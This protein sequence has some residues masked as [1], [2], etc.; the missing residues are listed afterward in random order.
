MNSFLFSILIL[1]A[2][3]TDKQMKE[4]FHIASH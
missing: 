1:I 4:E 2:M 3:Y